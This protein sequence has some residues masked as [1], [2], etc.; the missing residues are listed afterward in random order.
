M[1]TSHLPITESSSLFIYTIIC[2][3]DPTYTWLLKHVPHLVLPLFEP[4][5]SLSIRSYGSA[6]TDAPASPIF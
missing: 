3:C 6:F 4:L 2:F 1:E 5:A